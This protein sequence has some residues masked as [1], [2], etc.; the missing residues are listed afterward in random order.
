MDAQLTPLVGRELVGF[1]L[2]RLLGEGGMAAVFHGENLLNPRIVRALKVVRPELAGRDEFRSRFMEEAAILEGLR[3]PNVVAFYG[4]RAEGPWLVMELELLQG[5]ALSDHMGRGDPISSAEA[6]R[7]MVEAAE[8]VAAAHSLGVI[9]RDLKPENLFLTHDG[10]IKVLDF[11]IARALD[12]ADRLSSA[13]VAGTVHGSPPYMA[14]EVCEGAT[15]SPAADVYALGVC[16]YELLAGKH[17]FALPDGSQ[18]SSTQMMYCHVHEAPPPLSTIVPAVS[19]DVAMLV[20]RM[21]AKQPT[22][23][24]ANATEL[25]HALRTVGQGEQ[26]PPPPPVTGS[27]TEFALPQLKPRGDSTK[28]QPTASRPAAATPTRSSSGNL[29]L[30]VGGVCSA[31]LLF[32]I[33]AMILPGRSDGDAGPDAG[34]DADPHDA[35]VGTNT[36]VPIVPVRGRVG[37]PLLLGLPSDQAGTAILGFRPSRGITA[38]DAPYDLQRHEVTWE[39]LEA[40]QEG[41]GPEAEFERPAHIPQEREARARLPVTGVPW[42]VAM[43]YCR[44]LEGSLPTEEQWEYAARGP[45]LRPYAWGSQRLDHTRTHVYRG[46]QAQPT[47][48]MTSSQDQTPGLAGQ[49]LFDL[50]GNAQEWTADLWREDLPSRDESWVQQGATSFRALRG[51][52]LAAEPPDRVPEFGAAYREPLCATGACPPAASK[53][54]EHV[55]FRCARALREVNT[56]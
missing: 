41:A 35:G 17:P 31:L 39:E 21:L 50:M 33:G 44:H 1:R 30:V 47:K 24:F 20:E 15:P 26:A 56:P 49:V 7:W 25:A 48:V 52:P 18:R 10:H 8:G 32:G 23:R 22:A 11:G 2:T 29:G 13:T 46:A 42:E 36:W 28:E 51:L 38:P 4:V 3:H 55:G 53:L 9:H 54:R 43:A 34:V 12:E 19:S 27:F 40:W 6:L 45:T 5:T 16:L 37:E 14:P